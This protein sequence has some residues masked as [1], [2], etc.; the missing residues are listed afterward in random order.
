VITLDEANIHAGL[1]PIQQRNATCRCRTRSSAD[2][3]AQ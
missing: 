1:R 3:G 2:K